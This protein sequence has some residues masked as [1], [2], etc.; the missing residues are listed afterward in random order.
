MVRHQ[1]QNEK[2]CLPHMVEYLSIITMHFMKGFHVDS[3]KIR[4]IRSAAA[5]KKMG[6]L[7]SEEY[8]HEPIHS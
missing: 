2:K 3:N 4:H 7:S 5:G 1:I 8:L 6:N